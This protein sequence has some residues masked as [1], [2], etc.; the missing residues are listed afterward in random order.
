[1][2]TAYST[3]LSI[4]LAIVVLLVAS[5]TA[6]D[7]SAEP[8]ATVRNAFGPAAGSKPNQCR[9]ACGGGCP[10]TC[11]T[12]VTYECTDAAQLRRVVTYDC[13]THPGCRIHDDCLDACPK[14]GDAARS[15]ATQCDAEIMDRFGFENAGAW[16]LGDGPYDGR[17]QFE[18]TRDEP[19][20]LEPAY[21][22]PDG[23]SR[24]CSGNS[25]MVEAR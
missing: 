13:G 14:T 7:A 9:G 23:A 25:W 2:N 3:V 20:A 19:R 1:M 22:C 10:K 17:I 6:V 4:A 21:S 18:Y 12:S 16:L 11:D 15:C 8:G 5:P 24:Q